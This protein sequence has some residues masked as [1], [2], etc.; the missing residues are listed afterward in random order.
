MQKSLSELAFEKEIIKS[1][2]DNGWH[3][4]PD[5][6]HGTEEKLLSNWRE[7]LNRQNVERLKDTPLTDE[8]FE[9]I[10]SQVFAINS[11]LEAARFLSTGQVIISREINGQKTDLILECFWSHDVA[12]G[13]NSYEVVNQI[14]RKKN[15]TT[16]QDHRFDVTLLISG[17]PVIHLELKREG[18]SIEQAYWQIRDYMGNGDFSGFYSLVQIF[19]ILNGSESR[20]FAR[21]TDYRSFNYTF[22]FGWADEKT[23][24]PIQESSQFI[25]HALRVPMGHKLMSLYT[26]A[27]KPKGILKVLRSYQIYAVEN[28]L[29]RL[30]NRTRFDGSLE[31]RLGG[32]IWH[33][34]GSGKTMTS[35]KVAQLACELKNVDKVIFLADRNEL[36]KQTFNEYSG[37][38]DDEDDV[39]ATKSSNKLLAAIL[40][41]NQRL[42]VTS[43]QKMD[44]VAKLGEQKKLNNIHIVFI[45]DE[46]H[47]STAGQMLS[48]IKLSYPTAVWFGFTGTPILDENSKG[49][50]IIKDGEKVKTETT[51]SLFG[52]RL[53]VYSVADGIFDKNVLG[54]DVRKNYPIPL[55]TLRNGIAKWKDPSMGEVYRDYL[56][57]K[58]VSDLEIEQELSKSFYEKEEWVQ[59]VSSYILDCWEQNSYNRQF[60]AMLAVNDIKSANRYFKVLKDNPLGLKI[61]VIYDPNGEYNEGSFEDISDLENAI[62]HYNQQFSTH[63]GLESVPQYKEDLMRRLARRDEFKKITTENHDQQL[64]LVIVVW[65]LLTG[66][67]APYLNTLYLD[68]VL[69]YANLIQAFSRTNRVLNEQKPYGIIEYFRSPILMSENIE[70]AFKLYSNKNASGAFFVPSKEENI[71]KINRT[72]EEISQLFPEKVDTT[73]GEI[74]P[75][76]YQLPEDEESQKQFAKFFNEFEKTMIALRQQGFA[77]DNPKE[78]KKV[79][80]SESQYREL[81][82]RYADLDKINREPGVKK[83]KFEIDPNLVSGTSTMID[84]DYLMKLINELAQAETKRAEEIQ[85]RIEPL[86]NQLRENDR[87]HADQIVDDVKT[88]KLAKVDSFFAIL[89]QYRMRAEHNQI[90]NFISRF[91]LDRECFGKLQAHHVLGKDDWKD[92]GLLDNLVKSADMDLV[93]T[94]FS[95]EKP[96]EKPNALK[97]KGYLR[98]KIKT[99]IERIILAR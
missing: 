31:D 15:R 11:P 74:L 61:A 6:S 51:A 28:I 5:L 59:Q 34:T 43:I 18:V 26:I 32:F 10:K 82:A 56:D 25:K 41:P 7:V 81:Q 38:V 65:Q 27:D 94:Q 1:L 2:D 78:T 98:D 88:G 22:C 80:F 21:P 37:F 24:Q 3:Y 46:A 19:G 13:K 4:R 92:F 47:R 79:I 66:F 52:S 93:I 75:N 55:R 87:L 68:K 71:A 12:G 45:V 95:Q 96:D 29:E 90:Q 83:A 57:K 33:T 54:F 91:G 48:R 53:H 73:S 49:I 85:E 39:T 77:W 84:E 97:L 58:K 36:V 72:F 99:E 70:K 50:E 64:D 40:N 9:Q 30:A 16:G 62:I 67:D 89:D 44:N 17:I 20:Y 8:E 42:I 63:F 86:F 69:D 14:T 35:F 76:F 60:S 23:N